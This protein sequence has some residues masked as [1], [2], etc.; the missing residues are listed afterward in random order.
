MQQCNVRKH[1]LMAF[2]C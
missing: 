1:N 2:D